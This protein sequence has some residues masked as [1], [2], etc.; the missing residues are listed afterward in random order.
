MSGQ[1]RNPYEPFDTSGPEHDHL[2]ADP[3]SART[4]GNRPAAGA[5]QATPGEVLSEDFTGRQNAG[6]FLGLDLEFDP[7]QEPSGGQEGAD[8]LGLQAAPSLRP[9]AP[10]PMGAG[11]AGGG[12][13][14][15]VLEADPSVFPQDAFE[16][17]E[18]ADYGIADEEEEGGVE[19]EFEVAAPR[20]R[21]GLLV[22][23]AFAI[24]LG[25]AGVLFGPD[26]VARFGG[27]EDVATAPRTRPRPAPAT[28]VAGAATPSLPLDPSD[29]TGAGAPVPVEDLGGSA[30]SFGA[31]GE[32]WTSFPTEDVGA[33][34]AEPF[35][36]S[37][38][39][40]ESLTSF[41]HETL[42]GDEE[43]LPTEI[44][45]PLPVPPSV[46]L[47]GAPTPSEPA[48]DGELLEQL[49]LSAEGDLVIY[50]REAS[51]SMDAI[52]SP[53][54]ISYPKVGMVRVTMESGEVFQGRL[55]ALGEERVWIDDE[56][57]RIGLDG[58]RVV[59]I[60]RMPEIL[61]TAEAP[62]VAS[63]NRVRL[64][65]PGGAIYGRVLSTREGEITVLTDEGAKITLKD[66]QVEEI[67]SPR[68][69]L[70]TKL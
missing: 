25:V 29:A 64:R 66:P 32:L 68:V 10:Y 59:S 58:T 19:P 30:G 39:P 33:N 38:D 44:A 67:G 47:G 57:G 23:G 65:V 28:S 61:A 63:G 15:D 12:G 43:P 27:G 14:D 4:E 37:G 56:P 53:T 49:G 55:V 2:A 46:A 24:G 26:L 31:D 54:R 9:T 3:G 50:S 51:F 36:S 45:E 69:R 18:E 41:L 70:V 16:D 6:D 11:G 40:L 17:D 20:S 60:E 7:V 52:H 62:S 5:R 42:R 35:G 13:E 48:L 1:H 21:A 22:G 34:G 8:V